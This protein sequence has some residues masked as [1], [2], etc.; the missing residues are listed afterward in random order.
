MY[1]NCQG[2]GDNWRKTV[3]RK[4]EGKIKLH[5]KIIHTYEN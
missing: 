2:G 4:S 5:F 1:V 3:P